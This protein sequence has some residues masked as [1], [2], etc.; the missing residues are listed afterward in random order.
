MKS[1]FSGPSAV[2][3]HHRIGLT[4]SV[5]LLILGG[6]SATASA[7]PEQYVDSDVV[8]AKTQGASISGTVW[9][10]APPSIYFEITIKDT[11]NDGQCANLAFQTATR[12]GWQDIDNACGV[13][14][15]TLVKSKW[16]LG[17]KGAGEVTFGVCRHEE[18]VYATDR[19][20]YKKE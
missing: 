4:L 10:I 19:N 1:V 16:N 6:V 7:Q 13:G 8:Q 5:L 12:S 2:R 20:S 17:G 18:C 14:K 15:Q 11:S 3:R 9:W